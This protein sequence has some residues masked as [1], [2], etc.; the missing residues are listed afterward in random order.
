MDA[1]EERMYLLQMYPFTLER[2]ARLKMAM[3]DYEASLRRA[4]QAYIDEAT[5]VEEEWTSGKARVRERLLE[6]IEERRRKA[7]EEKDG[8]GIG[9]GAYRPLVLC[10][11]FIFPQK[12]NKDALEQNSQL[13]LRPGRTSH[14]KRRRNWPLRLAI[15]HLNRRHHFF[16][17]TG[18][19]FVS[20]TSR[21]RFHLH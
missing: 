17:R 11:L 21:H 15:R 7:R 4:E 9:G 12:T 20:K 8:D 3:L 13:M 10:L 2:S 5:R 14:A 18:T 16:N 6:G 1:S 19:R